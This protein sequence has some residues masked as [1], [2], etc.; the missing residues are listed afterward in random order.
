M[1]WH[2]YIWR[3]KRNTTKEKSNAKTRQHTHTHTHAR[4]STN[5]HTQERAHLR[6]HKY[7]IPHQYETVQQLTNVTKPDH[8]INYYTVSTTLIIP[9]ICSI[10]GAHLALE[11]NTKHQNYVH[12]LLD[13]VRSRLIM[14]YLK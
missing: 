2:I 1:L 13:K 5:T 8:I 6:T 10:A 9:Y 7:N 3:K 11:E 4:K 12:V 14:F